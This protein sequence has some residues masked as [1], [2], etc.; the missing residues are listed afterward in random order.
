MPR[1]AGISALLLRRPAI[2]IA[3]FMCL[4]APSA[5]A[6]IGCNQADLAPPLGVLDLADVNAFVSSFTSQHPAADLDNNGVFDLIDLSIFIS[7][8]LNGCPPAAC[9]P[10]IRTTVTAPSD[11]PPDV[12]A[13]Y[14][15]IN[16]TIHLFGPLP[17]AQIYASPPGDLLPFIFDR[18]QTLESCTG[19][20]TDVTALES[21]YSLI[22]ELAGTRTI[23]Q[24]VAAPVGS[25]PLLE[26]ALQQL[27]DLGVGVPDLAPDNLASQGR[28][29][30]LPILLGGAGGVTLAD[31]FFKT[32]D[33]VTADEYFSINT[34]KSSGLVAAS[35]C[36]NDKCCDENG[37]PPIGGFTTD[38]CLSERR[39]CNLPPPSRI[40][41]SIASDKCE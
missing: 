14:D 7:A 30:V 19:L 15:G 12:Q 28:L 31:L 26:D 8:F 9:Y 34:G 23:G 16:R 4:G 24:I 5:S 33:D 21:V 40:K 3:G 29:N 27:R 6:G 39:L 37:G 22:S 20:P 36:D 35:I 38:R 25:D 1:A 2:A 10:D 13:N 17:V 32:K 11:D 18:I 41:C